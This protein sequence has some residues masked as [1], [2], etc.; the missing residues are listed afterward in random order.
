MQGYHRRMD[1]PRSAAI[2]GPVLAHEDVPLP[3]GESGVRAT[4]RDLDLQDRFARDGYVVVPFLDVA[5]VDQIRAIYD[6]VGPPPDDDHVG[7]FPGNASE[8]A[9]WKRTVIDAV[10]P[11]VQARIEELFDRHHVFHL[12]FMTK[13]PGPDGRLQVHQDPTMV[14]HEGRYRSFNVWCPISAPAPG[15]ERER[16]M[17]RVVPGS[18]HLSTA[19]WYRA[20]G[21]HVPSGLEPTEDLVARDLAERVPTELGEA[22]VLDHRAV[23]WSP[24][25]MSDEPRRILA[26]GLRPEESPCVHVEC[27]EDGWVDFYTVDDE[28]FIRHPNVDIEDYPLVRRLHA[29]PA[30]SIEIDDLEDL[31][32]I[33]IERPA[34]APDPAPE[35][36]VPAAAAEA[37]P[38]TIADEVAVAGT[39]PS[40]TLVQRLATSASS[41]R[42]QLSWRDWVPAR[43]SPSAKG[44]ARVLRDDAADLRLHRDGFA[45]VPL[46]S[47]SDVAD[48]KAEIAA[49]PAGAAHVVAATIER[50]LDAVCNDRRVVPGLV[51]RVSVFGTRGPVRSWMFTDEDRSHRS[52]VAFLALDDIDGDRGLLKVVRGSQRLDAMP[53]GTNL[54]ATWLAHTDVLEQRLLS[55]PQ[56]AGELTL[57]DA[58]LVHAV[59]ADGTG[60]APLRFRAVLTPASAPLVH[61][62]RTGPETA[63]RH[64]LPEDFF[65]DRGLVPVGDQELDPGTTVAVRALHYG[66]AG[67]ARR[68]DAH[69]LALL[70][71]MRRTT[72]TR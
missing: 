11:L 13:W 42:G 25:N 43:W 62:R 1:D 29:R 5:T 49:D 15:D 32:G 17:V 27:H 31:L 51:E 14:D 6:E 18:T 66:P 35:V 57:V 39:E 46:L 41:W 4:F 37:P 44:A 40:A 38:A 9:D 20:R 60:T 26:I 58:E 24:P 19:N 21:G 16:G 56:R 10:T 3:P 71:R 30:P 63:E 47:A 2:A 33:E 59:L 68:L 53:R 64:E 45:T 34:P 67:L 23:H 8:S 12:T 61:L 65:E 7:Y 69:P 36:T 22:I 70:D 72:S 55:L 48:L 50:H 28:Y 52:H 54:S